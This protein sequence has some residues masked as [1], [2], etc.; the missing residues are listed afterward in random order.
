M[1]NS[2][3]HLNALKAF[4]AAAKHSSFSKAALEL[5][6]SH[7]VVSQHIKNLEQWLG[8][9]LF[10]RH[11][12]RIELSEEAHKLLPQVANAFQ[13]LRDACDGV[14]HSNLA[15]NITISA[16]PAIASRWLRI[17]ITQF[18]KEYPFIN[19]ILKPAWE[20][21]VL[22]DQG[23]D[24]VVHFEERLS[25]LGTHTKRLFAI[26]GFPACSAKMH[27][28]LTSQNTD[29]TLSQL[30]LIHD[31]G[32]EIWRKWFEKY[33]PE[34]SAWEHGQVYSDLSLAIDAA[35]DG[36]GV[37]LADEV[38]CQKEL[39]SGALI[40]LDERSTRCTWCS[41]AFD[42]SSNKLKTITE[43]VEWLST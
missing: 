14:R 2:L 25:A 18:C 22:G 38:L 26:D 3:R 31:N 28:Q 21:P 15:T 5:N 40:K 23:A 27:E 29:I 10:T 11:G 39:A 6:V 42:K 4:E 37:I 34:H 33:L 7:S 1:A 19:V 20:A 35:I 8:I 13:T 36:E 43:L 9:E 12:N 41:S 17:R 32:H 24:I 16:E 30:P